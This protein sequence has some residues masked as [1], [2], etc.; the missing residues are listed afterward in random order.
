MGQ[1]RREPSAPT[2][3]L[4]SAVREIQGRADLSDAEFS[5]RSGIP[6]SSLRKIRRGEMAI[7]YEQMVMLARALS[8]S[9]ST[10]AQRAEELEGEQP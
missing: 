4:A 9:V 2:R 10:L 3:A 1:N 6:Y 7:D 5:R 8:V